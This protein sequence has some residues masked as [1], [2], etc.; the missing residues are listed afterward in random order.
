MNRDVAFDATLT[1]RMRKRKVK[2][3]YWRCV[4][5]FLWPQFSRSP[6]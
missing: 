3:V 6:R 1:T 4:L 5:S 2:L